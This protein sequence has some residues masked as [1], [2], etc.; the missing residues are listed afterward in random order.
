MSIFLIYFAVEASIVTK[1]CP[2]LTGY[3][4][5]GLISEVTTRHCIVLQHMVATARAVTWTCGT[6]NW[7]F[8]TS[9]D[10]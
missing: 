3:S 6:C 9:C 2:L 5:R 10:S 8:D 1:V 4:V 7:S